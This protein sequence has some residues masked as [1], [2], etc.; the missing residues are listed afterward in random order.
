MSASSR[1]A[2]LGGCDVIADTDARSGKNY[3]MVVVQEDTVFNALTGTNGAGGTVDFQA[4]MG[5]STNTLKQ[6]AILSTPNGSVITDLDLTSGSV[7]AYKK[8]EQ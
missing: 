4:T 8:S 5:V 3:V 6:G 7:I 1:I 2:G